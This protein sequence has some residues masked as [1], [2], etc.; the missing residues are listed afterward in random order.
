ME[1]SSVKYMALYPSRRAV[2]VVLRLLGSESS[3]PDSLHLIS[4]PVKVQAPG[5]FPSS[6]K[7]KP[8]Q[9]IPLSH[10]GREMDSWLLP[11][12]V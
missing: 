2:A 5:D 10:S 9:F 3:R 1:Q 6:N 4:P 7:Q 12:G 11:P 8:H